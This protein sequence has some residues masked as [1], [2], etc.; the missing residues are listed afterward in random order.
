[1]SEVAGCPNIKLAKNVAKIGLLR[2]LHGARHHTA[3]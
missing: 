1:M 3:S 2:N